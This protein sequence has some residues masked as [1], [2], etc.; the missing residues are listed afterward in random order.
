MPPCGHVSVNLDG[1]T[2]F[3]IFPK[4]AHAASVDPN[5]AFFEASLSVNSSAAAAAI[6]K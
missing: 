2:K 3:P 6:R 1:K 4:L 5:S